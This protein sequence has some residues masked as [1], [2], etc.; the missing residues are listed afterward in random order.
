M[1]IFSEE[2]ASKDNIKIVT[3]NSKSR[4]NQNNNKNLLSNKNKNIN[5]KKFFYYKDFAQL[6]NYYNSMS[7]QQKSKDLNNVN[8]IPNSQNNKNKLK[9]NLTFIKPE[10]QSYIIKK[11]KKEVKKIINNFEKNKIV[12]EHLLSQEKKLPLNSVNET[13]FLF[14][15]NKRNKKKGR[16]DISQMSNTDLSTSSMIKKFN[17]KT[18]GLLDIS[19]P[20]KIYSKELTELTKDIINNFSD[21]ILAT[22]DFEYYK[23]KNKK[24]MNNLRLFDDLF[25]QKALETEKQF[26]LAKY[27]KKLSKDNKKE[28]EKEKEKDEKNE[29]KKKN[30]LISKLIKDNCRNIEKIRIKSGKNNT[31]ND[32]NL[33]DNINID[34]LNKIKKNRSRRN[35]LFLENRNISNNK[36]EKRN[37]LIMSEKDKINRNSFNNISRIINNPL[38][39]SK[40]DAKISSYNLN[41]I[42][43]KDC[44]KIYNRNRMKRIKARS[45]DYANS[46]A[47]LNYMQYEP[48]N[49]TYMKVN[50]NNLKRV[51]KI[52]EIKKYKHNL[53]DDDL[54]LYNPKL[55]RDKIYKTQMNYYHSYFNK[56][57]HFNFIKKKF[58]PQT[59]RKFSYIKDSYF[60]IPC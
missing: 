22:N 47:E 60:G 58:R 37:S 4:N 7:S 24:A 26:Y 16:K 10:D 3:Y 21:K 23:T 44:H 28:K 50:D 29:L 5:L 33:F 43:I 53:Q 39:Y 41:E 9:K 19:T 14:L 59:I 55:L 11:V 46:L 34:I 17:K 2:K 48:M 38:K 57:C 27:N 1:K 42:S 8:I 30:S 36:I 35:T 40:K 56:E 52:S 18:S 20:V 6:K 54:L 49:Q 13:N 31:L 51:I 32:G 12:T 45:R 25:V 15:L